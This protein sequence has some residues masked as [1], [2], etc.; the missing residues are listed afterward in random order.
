[1]VKPV[2]LPADNQSLKEMLHNKIEHLDSS[3]LSILNRVALQ[4]E[5]ERT[6]DALDAAFDEDRK[7][8]K[9]SGERVRKIISEVR[10]EHPYR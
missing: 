1:M 4:L 2:E 5:A 3:D 8:G 10:K 9:L 7:A 6:A